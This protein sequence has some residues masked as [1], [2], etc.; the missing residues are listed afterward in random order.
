MPNQRMN[1]VLYRGIHESR[2]WG[3]HSA[4]TPKEP[5]PFAKL[6]KWDVSEW[7][8]STWHASSI[9]AVIEHQHDQAGSPTSGLSTTPLF[10]R[11]RIYALGKARQGCGYVVSIDVAKCLARGIQQYVV[12]NLVRSPAVPED[13]EVILVAP[14]FGVFPEE[15]VREVVKVCA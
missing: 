11:A 4:L 8:N 2:Y 12:N 6:P 7:D 3:L 1:T 10:E 9:N 5:A 13:N 15:I 14:S